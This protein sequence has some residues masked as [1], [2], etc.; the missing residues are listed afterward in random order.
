M[1]TNDIPCGL[2]AETKVETPEGSLTARGLAGKNVS[3]FTREP[4]GRVR[5]RRTLNARCVGENQP[6]LR[7]VL[8]TGVGFRVAPT[9]ILYKKGMVE[10]RADTLQP[11]DALIPTFHYREGY[12]YRDDTSGTELSSNQAIVVTAVE[13]AGNGDIY[14]FAVN[15]TGNF[16]LT[17]GV[18]CKAEP[19]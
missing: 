11:G 10:V 17:A 15:R 7:V 3:V 4:E 6:L 9:Q 14:A 2:A 8:E 16:S 13:P 19:A 12:R 1:T 18:L 5:F